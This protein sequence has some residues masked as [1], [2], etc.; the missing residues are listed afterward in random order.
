MG[1]RIL[2][3]ML[4]RIASQGMVKTDDVVIVL[5]GDVDVGFELVEGT[6]L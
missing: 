6:A 1:V 2:L 3:S 4:A 5:W